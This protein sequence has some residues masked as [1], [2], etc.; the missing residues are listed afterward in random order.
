M[1][2]KSFSARTLDAGALKSF[3]H[4]LR[5]RMYELL[6]LHGPQTATQLAAKVGQN[7]GATSYHLREL[8]GHGLIEV[9]EGMGKGKEKYWR[10]VPGG[11]TYGATSKEGDPE[12]AAALDFLLRD[13]VRFR[14]AELTRWL[15][16]QPDAPREW[17]RAGVLARRSMLLTVEETAELRDRVME[18]LEHYRDLSDGRDAVEGAERVVAHFDLLPVGTVRPA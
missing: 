12:T 9:A 18:V 2:G 10:I 8:A 4:P 14:G 15:E 11:F 16:E 13:L 5:L 1:D 6:D 17:S 3:A 7:T